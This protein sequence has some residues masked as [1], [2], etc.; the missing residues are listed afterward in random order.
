MVLRQYTNFDAFHA[1]GPWLDLV[2]AQSERYVPLVKPYNA[3]MHLGHMASYRAALR[4]SYGQT[5]LDIGCGVGYGDHFLA[6]FGARQV[7]GIDVSPQT[8]DYA[9]QVYQH[10]RVHYLLG[11]GLTLPFADGSFD[12]VFSAQVI[13]HVASV[14]AFLAEV[15][16]VLKSTGACLIAT[17]N[18]LLFTPT[19]GDSTNIYHLSEMDVT[20]FQE[21]MRAVFPHVHPYGIA[22]NCLFMPEGGSEP[23]VKSNR[24]IKPEDYRV[25]RADLELCENLLCFGSLDVDQSSIE[26]H[27]SALP[28]GVLSVAEA[29][30]PCFWDHS[31]ARWVTLGIFPQGTPSG[32]HSTGVITGAPGQDLT[33]VFR[34]PYA[35]M[36][37]VEVDLVAPRPAHVWVQIIRVAGGDA[38]VAQMVCPQEDRVVVCFPAQMDSAG[39]SYMLTLRGVDGE[40][41]VVADGVVLDGRLEP[42]QLAL[43]TFHCDL[44]T[45]P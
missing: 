27:V 22:Q 23:M 26:A 2:S 43:R 11:D 42:Y 45:L 38:V 15:R 6:T 19:G 36:Y 21:A 17:P 32:H 16:R 28:S 10:P 3:A 41:N 25:Q 12:F 35:Y 30:A 44:P 31:S 18:K 5:V 14:A 20:A 4:Y 39:E 8:I 33:Q 24:E 13:E 40:I 9:R 29:L 34:A 1:A 37:R 7:V